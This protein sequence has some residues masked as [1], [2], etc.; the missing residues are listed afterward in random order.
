MFAYG[1]GLTYMDKGDLASLPEDSGLGNQA[2][3][4]VD[5]YF[6]AGRVK[7]PWT[8]DLIDGAGKTAGDHD[9][10]KS[11]NGAVAQSPVDAGKQEAGRS[12]VF[13]GQGE[14]AFVS[15]PVDI[16]RQ[17][18][19]KM[20]VAVTY[21]LDAPVV[22]PVFIGVGKDVASEHRI[23]VSKV[24]TAPVG[25]WAT[26]KIKLDCYV[27]AGMDPKAIGVPFAL[28]TKG[29]LS[30]SYSSVKLASDEG[31]AVCPAK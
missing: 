15:D 17:T 24:L 26:L 2:V 12:L 29:P 27:A 31:D 8:L 10:F 23:E 21:R 7:A 20:A 5:T 19:G 9:P 16:S 28:S 22:G 14:A 25:K 13:T 18:L 11:P 1:Y 3:V 4:N 30:I 6:D